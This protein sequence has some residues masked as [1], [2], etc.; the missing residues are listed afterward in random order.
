MST[1]TTPA[2]GR[3]FTVADVCRRYGVGEHTVLGWIGRGE[4]KA[5]NVAR[6]PGAKRPRWRITSAAIEEFERLRTPVPTT[7]RARRR[8]TAG[9]VIE[10]YR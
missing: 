3:T 10:F 5:V 8:K 7:P 1:D 4:L 6:K 9:G 2:P